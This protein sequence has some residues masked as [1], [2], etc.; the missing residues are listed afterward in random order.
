M[1]IT[2]SW[3]D[4]VLAKEGVA[5]GIYQASRASLQ[6]TKTQFGNFESKLNTMMNFIGSNISTASNDF[7]D[8]TKGLY[9]EYM[10]AIASAKTEALSKI[11]TVRSLQLARFVK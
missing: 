7:G 5:L 10:D 1:R 4:E 2:E 11:T 8:E 6:L 9:K 3:T